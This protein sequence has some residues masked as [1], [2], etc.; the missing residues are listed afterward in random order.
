MTVSSHTRGYS[1]RRTARGDTVR[2]L[3]RA[4]FVARGVVYLL[5]GWI[6]LLIAFQHNTTNAIQ[7]KSASSR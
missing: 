3:G 6:T 2:A 5:I 1:A 4:G 7:S